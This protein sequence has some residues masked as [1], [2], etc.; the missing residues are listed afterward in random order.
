[1]FLEYSIIS[2]DFIFLENI[3]YLAT[4]GVGSLVSLIYMIQRIIVLFVQSLVDNSL[5]KYTQINNNYKYSLLFGFVFS[6]VLSIIISLIFFSSKEFILSFFKINPNAKFYA[7][8]Y[9]DYMILFL[10]IFSIQQYFHYIL[11]SLK[12]AKLN[13]IIMI[14]MV[15]LNF[16]FNYISFYILKIG[17]VGIAIAS[18]LALLFTLPIYIYIIVKKK[19]WFFKISAL[20]YKYF[21]NSIVGIKN[22]GFASIIEPILVQ[23]VDV[24]IKILIVS[25]V[26]QEALSARVHSSNYF[27]LALSFSVALGICLQMLFSKL[28]GKHNIKIVD[29]IYKKSLIF[30]L[31]FVIIL[32][33]VVYVLVYMNSNIITKNIQVKDYILFLCAFAV[34][35]EPIRML[36]IASKSYLKGMQK[37][38]IVVIITFAI[39]LCVVYPLIY[40]FLTKFS[41]GL[42]AIVLAELINY[43][44]NFICYSA[45]VMFYKKRFLTYKY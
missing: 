11:Y 27:T 43:M 7:L 9:I 40:I 32:S 13:L 39:K 37:G 17:V 41:M 19:M 5:Y 1:M 33:V 8:Q 22:I 26:A 14:Y 42:Y 15:A 38:N 45:S 30:G 3:S 24:V 6:I 31:M 35:L 18:N 29:K 25:F 21:N 16:I 4:I 34:I 10:I 44:L 28:L 12:L 20:S 23:G 36:S 2:I